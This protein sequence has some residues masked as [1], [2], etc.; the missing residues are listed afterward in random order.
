MRIV[1]RRRRRLLRALVISPAAAL[2][3]PVRAQAQSFPS[4]P[5]RLICPWPPG[6]ASDIVMRAL[7][8]SAGK[9]LGGIFV[10]DNKP[11]GSGMLGPNE[12][13][14][15]KPDGYTLS[16]FTIGVARLPHLQKLA[17]DPLRDFT[18]IVRLTGYTHGLVVRADSSFRSIQDVVDYAKA[19]PERLSFG[20]PG[21]GTT[22]HL[23]V[24]EFAW[25]AGV[26]LLHVPYKGYA[27]GIQGLLGGHVMAYSD[28]TGWGSQ[29]DAGACRLLATYGAKRTHRWPSVPTLQE[30][31]YETLAESPYGIGGPMGMEP[32]VTRRLH[33]AFKQTLDDPVVLAAF[34]KFDQPVLYLGTEDYTRYMR[35]QFVREKGIVER[36]GLLLKS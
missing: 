34:E 26:K 4:R 9:A 35:E 16:Q 20:S 1:D 10:I 33:D 29:V 24:E 30:L 14:K 36:L 11:G 27:E 22:A 31:G 21:I 18:Y 3:R 28:T 15:A 17:F 12:L 2:A 25:R 32:A 13:L 19:N 8:E 6:G 5:I 23:A 7:A